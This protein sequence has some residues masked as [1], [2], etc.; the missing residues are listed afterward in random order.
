MRS[1]KIKPCRK[2]GALLGG[3]SELLRFAILDAANYVRSLPPGDEIGQPASG[4]CF[5]ILDIEQRYREL[6]SLNPKDSPQ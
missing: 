1:R 6:H 2:C 5:M 4:L 3:D